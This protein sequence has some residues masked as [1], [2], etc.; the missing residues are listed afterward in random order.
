MSPSSRCYDAAG[1]KALT[2]VAPNQET[3]GETQHVRLDVS[4]VVG[5]TFLLQV[6]DYAMNVSTYKVSY[7]F[8][9]DIDGYYTF[10]DLNKKQ[11]YTYT[12]DGSESAA[13]GATNLKLYAAEY[14]DGYVFAIDEKN[15]LYVMPDNDFANVTKIADL[16]AA[17]GP[18][19]YDFFVSDMAYNAAEKEMYFLAYS[20]ANELGAS[21][22]FKLDLLTGATSLVGEMGKDIWT[23]ASDGSNGFYGQGT[24][25]NKLYHFTAA[26]FAEPED[27]GALDD[28]LSIYMA[29][30]SLAWDAKNQKLVFTLATASSFTGQILNSAIYTNR[31]DDA[32]EQE[33]LRII[34]ACPSSSAA[35]SRRAA[36]TTP[37]ILLPAPR[38]W[39]SPCPKARCPSLSRKGHA[40][41]AGQPVDA[42]RPQRDVVQLR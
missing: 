34:P 38:P 7:D 9:P 15:A 30:S 33:V 2:Y 28:E 36:R 14:A 41:R 42:E 25:D 27:L 8:L 3:A 32:R 31:S 17:S 29:Q 1:S 11:W 19:S 21:Y 40:D 12:E 20:E 26:T 22:L 5:K 4:K 6:Y 35:M 39:R 24:F 18:L 10:F 37:P 13:M 16:G 23:L